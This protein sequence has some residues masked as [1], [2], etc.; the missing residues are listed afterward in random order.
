MAH[1]KSAEKAIRQTKKR[2]ERNIARKTRIK[3]AVKKVRATVAANDTDAAKAA[4]ITSQKE[5]DRAVS[6]GLI[7][8]KT[9]SRTKSRLNAAVKK[10]A[11]AK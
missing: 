4:L 1:H 7:K 8:K 5:L 10:V 6:K 2:T 9:A 11:T 3:S